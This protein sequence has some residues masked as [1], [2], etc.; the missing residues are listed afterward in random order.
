[1]DGEWSWDRLGGKILSRTSLSWHE[2]ERATVCQ[3]ELALE[4]SSDTKDDSALNLTGHGQ[5]LSAAAVTVMQP[6]SSSALT[7]V[8]HWV[9]EVDAMQK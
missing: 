7:I 5:Y 6:L 4:Y 8:A 1:M 2:A 3:Q 9:F